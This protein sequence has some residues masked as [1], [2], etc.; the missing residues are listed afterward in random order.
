M[1][2]A[3]TYLSWYQSL[4]ILWHLKLP[5]PQIGQPLGIKVLDANYEKS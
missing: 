4:Y 2:H 1:H 5:A 3:L